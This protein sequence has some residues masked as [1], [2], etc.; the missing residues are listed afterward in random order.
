MP[1]PLGAEK[2]TAEFYQAVG[3]AITEW[4]QIDGELFQISAN[5]L[6]ANLRHTAIVY[7]R[8]Q[9]LDQRLTL[10]GDLVATV[11]HE[12]EKKSGGHPHDLQKSWETLA[13][14]TRNEL[15][16]RNQLAHSPT[17]LTMDFTAREGQKPDIWWA[18]FI[19]GTE[20]MRRPKRKVKELRTSDIENHITVLRSLLD[21][22]RFYRTSL[23]PIINENIREYGCSAA[24]FQIE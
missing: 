12:P 18:S 8:L 9:S 20:R 6:Q 10:T 23:V 1:G 22:F 17:A 11:F 24:P 16:T 19:S 13:S 21:R 5:I 3:R 7:Y 2:E 4:A 14:E 15:Q